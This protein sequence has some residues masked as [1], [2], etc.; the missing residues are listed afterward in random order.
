MQGHIVLFVFCGVGIHA[1]MQAVHYY[2]ARR[3][4]DRSHSADAAA[5]AI[6][7]SKRDRKRSEKP[8]TAA[9]TTTTTA[10]AESPADTKRLMSSRVTSLALWGVALSLLAAGIAVYVCVLVFCFDSVFVCLTVCGVSVDGCVLC[11]VVTPKW[12]TTTRG[13]CIDTLNTSS[14]RYPTDLWS[15]SRETF[16]I[17]P[18]TTC[19]CARTTDLMSAWVRIEHLK[20]CS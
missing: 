1:L 3:K 4:G 10:K 8:V 18:C 17:T 16:I 19:K 9:T 12:I 7:Q 5:A 2:T 13:S 15:L 6:A 14:V 20:Q 11:A